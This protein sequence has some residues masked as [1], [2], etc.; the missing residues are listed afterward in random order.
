MPNFIMIFGSPLSDGALSHLQLLGDLR[1]E[2]GGRAV[3]LNT[4]GTIQGVGITE[5]YVVAFIT[6]AHANTWITNADRALLMTLTTIS[7]PQE[8]A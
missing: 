1:I 3:F 7:E 6:V 2:C 8:D 5:A 4:P